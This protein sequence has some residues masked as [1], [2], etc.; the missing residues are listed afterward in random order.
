MSNL[1]AKIE[2]THPDRAGS[3]L[4]GSATPSTAPASPAPSKDAPTTNPMESTVDI[5]RPTE[6]REALAHRRH[7]P[8][9]G[10][11]QHALCRG[12]VPPGERLPPARPP[13]RQHHRRAPAPSAPPRPSQLMTPP[14]TMTTEDH[15]KIYGTWDILD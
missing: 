15:P 4:K 1:G 13:R 2:R 12:A 5:I 9:L 11:R 8:T 14:A 10:C 7:G 3:L 6:E